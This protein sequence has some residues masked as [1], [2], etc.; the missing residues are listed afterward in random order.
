MLKSTDGLFGQ[1]LAPVNHYRGHILFFLSNQSAELCAAF[2]L[3]VRSQQIASAL[4]TAGLDRQDKEWGS[5]G[6][7][8]VDS[9]LMFDAGDPVLRFG[10]ALWLASL[11]QRTP[12]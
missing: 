9:P 6:K 10:P 8:D 3:K 2:G 7:I 12:C 1:L 5:F 11:R 4:L